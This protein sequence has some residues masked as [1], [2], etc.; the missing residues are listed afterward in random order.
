MVGCSTPMRETRL[1]QLKI[2]RGIKNIEN[3][4]IIQKRISEQ[5][6]KRDKTE[7]DKV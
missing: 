1:T 6:K 4:H 5:K 2:F 3:T 7:R